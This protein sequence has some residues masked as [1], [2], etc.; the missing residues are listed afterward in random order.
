[1]KFDIL[2]RLMV[3]NIMRR[4]MVEPKDIEELTELREYL[5]GVPEQVQ[6]L[7]R[8]ITISMANYGV[9][10]GVLYQLEASDFKLRWEVFGWPKKIARQVRRRRTRQYAARAS[11]LEREMEEEQEAYREKLR[12]MMD[13]VDNLKIYTDLKRI[14]QVSNYVRRIKKETSPR[15]RTR[16][17]SST[18]A[19]PSSTRIL[20]STRFSRT[21]AR[22]SSR[23]TTCGTRSTSG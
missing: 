10:E 9:L 23:T 17:A 3:D 22:T 7:E 11:Q 19:R 15:P 14:D 20:P 1:M 2:R 12:S 18:R 8:Q 13:E 6:A 4:V 16:A 5:E 21:S